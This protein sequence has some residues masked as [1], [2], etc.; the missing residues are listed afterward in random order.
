MILLLRWFFSILIYGRAPL[1][2][3]PVVSTP[4][5]THIHTFT[6][7]KLCES[8][9]YHHECDHCG[10]KHE[11]EG[12]ATY[13]RICTECGRYE[14]KEYCTSE[15]L[16]NTDAQQALNQLIKITNA[17]FET[18]TSNEPVIPTEGQ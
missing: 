4:E 1:K 2:K 11:Y 18:E 7:W 17:A 15:Y 14:I 12:R 8:N 9:V 3:A 6:K 10:S 16:E 13:R 5:P